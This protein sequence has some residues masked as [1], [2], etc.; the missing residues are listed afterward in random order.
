[1]Q[2]RTSTEHDA[3]RF[4]RSLAEPADLP[5]PDEYSDLGQPGPHD[6]DVFAAVQASFARL[7]GTD[8]RDIW[9]RRYDEEKARKGAAWRALAIPEEEIP[10]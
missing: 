1:M 5:G 10:F 4:A 9:A 8:G 6:P 2:D 7:H 3:G